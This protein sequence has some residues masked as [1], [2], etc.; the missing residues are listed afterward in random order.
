MTDTLR[1]IA[2]L[3]NLDFLLVIHLNEN[4]NYAEKR[5]LSATHP[6]LPASLPLLPPFRHRQL[7][8]V[9]DDSELLQFSNLPLKG[10]E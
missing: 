3:F 2:P 4:N 7:G 10:H 8:H 6:H 1:G 5:F 9:Y